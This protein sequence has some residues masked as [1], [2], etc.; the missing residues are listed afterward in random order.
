MFY[1][2]RNESKY[3]AS[4]VPI[5]LIISD[6]FVIWRASV[7]F[8]A[9]RWVLFIPLFFLLATTGGIITVSFLIPN[10]DPLIFLGVMFA[11]MGIPFSNYIA[12]NIL[13]WL[14]LALSLATNLITTGLI[15]W[16]L[17][18]VIIES[19]HKCYLLKVL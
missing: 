14:L 4:Y 12:S 9:N 6:T 1:M 2:L 16:R 8:T 11:N 10:T 13:S 17:W 7:L 3:N 5:K 18:Y 15:G 19:E